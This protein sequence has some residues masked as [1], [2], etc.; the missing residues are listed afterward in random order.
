MC[1]AARPRGGV[2]RRVQLVV[3]PLHGK[4]T[5]A[6]AGDNFS[7]VVIFFFCIFFLNCSGEIEK[8]LR[9]PGPGAGGV[10]VGRGVRVRK[11]HLE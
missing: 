4:S 5:G 7:V 8:C 3:C 11:P 6:E 2:R 10:P 9:E 1:H